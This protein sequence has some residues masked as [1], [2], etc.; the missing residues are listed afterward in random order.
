MT[1]SGILSF[2]P[3]GL[4]EDRPLEDRWEL[5]ALRHQLGPKPSSNQH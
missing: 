2:S 3:S 5:E 1:L 4:H